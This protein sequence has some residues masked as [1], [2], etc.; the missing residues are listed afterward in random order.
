MSTHARRITPGEFASRHGICGTESTDLTN[1]PAQVDCGACVALLLAPVNEWKQVLS[2][3]RPSGTSKEPTPAEIAASHRLE[4]LGIELKEIIY[5]LRDGTPDAHRAVNA[6]R[7][8]IS[9]VAST[10]AMPD[11]VTTPDLP[12]DGTY[13]A[14]KVMKNWD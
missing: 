4:E 1:S 14:D 3:W 8:K 5:Q 12:D 7:Q 10:L 9:R 6:F 13:S 11:G 2:G